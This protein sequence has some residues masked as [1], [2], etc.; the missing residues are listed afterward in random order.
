MADGDESCARAG[1][2]S[3]CNA[4]EASLVVLLIETLLMEGVPAPDIGV[5]TL[6]KAQQA[7]ISSQLTASKYVRR[8]CMS[9]NL[10]YC[11]RSSRAKFCVTYM[12]FGVGTCTWVY[13]PS[14]CEIIGL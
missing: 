13:V 9:K 8:A 5:I 3:F 12:Y 4:R 6:Y 1:G 11:A 10:R 14:G 2:G 7:L